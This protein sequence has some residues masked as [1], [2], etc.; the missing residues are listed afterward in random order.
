MLGPDLGSPVQKIHGR[1]GVGQAS[2]HKNDKGLQVPDIQSETEGAGPVQP[3]EEM[4]QGDLITI[5]KYPMG[6]NKES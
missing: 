2:N 6:D 1:T 3:G 5:Y 4:T